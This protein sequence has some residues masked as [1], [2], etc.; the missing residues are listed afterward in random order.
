[1]RASTPIAAMGSAANTPPLP[2]SSANGWRTT[3]F[4]AEIP[5]ATRRSSHRTS[6]VAPTLL[7]LHSYNTLSALA[8]TSDVIIL[9][10]L[11][12]SRACAHVEVH[13]MPRM[14]NPSIRTVYG[15]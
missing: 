10:T 14:H 12:I 4:G 5:L 8:L 11:C 3:S 1:M 15:R 13:V 9:L 2:R 7:Q 6:D